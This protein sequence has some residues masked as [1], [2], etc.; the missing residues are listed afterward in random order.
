MKKVESNQDITVQTK[1]TDVKN[2]GD[3]K[4]TVTDKNGKDITVSGL[5]LI[6]I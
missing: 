3:S 6:H 5:S 2:S 4:I 1:D